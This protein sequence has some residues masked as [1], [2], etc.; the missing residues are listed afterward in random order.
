MRQITITRPDDWHLHVRDHELLKQVIGHAAK[1]FSRAIIMPNLKPP[2]VTVAMA[3]DYRQRIVQALP[4]NTD[5]QPL[6]TLYMTDSTSVRDVKR[7]AENADIIGYKLYPAGATTHSEAGVSQLEYIYPCL[8]AM[9]RFDVPL[10]V[11]G[12]VTDSSSDIFDREKLFIDR[13]LIQIVKRF[14]GLRVIME[15]VTTRK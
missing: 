4:P 8:E 6:M 9:E 10:L 12:E 2:V 11:H 1:Q 7:V 3:L 15:H 14:P 5:F 13:Y